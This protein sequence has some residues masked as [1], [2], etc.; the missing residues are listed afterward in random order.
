MKRR[1]RRGHA[2]VNRTLQNDFLNLFTRHLIAQR[3]AHMHF[4]FLRAIEGNGHAQRHE[5]PRMARKSRARPDFSPCVACDQVL[6]RLG[7]RIHPR[8]RLIHVLIAKHRPAHFE[9]LRIAIAVVHSL[10][11]YSRRN[12]FTAPVNC[13]GAST[14]A[15]CEAGTSTHWAPGMPFAKNCASRGGVTGSW[16]PTIMRV[17]DL[18]AETDSRKSPSRTAAQHAAYP[19]PGV[20]ISM[21]RMDSSVAG[22]LVKNSGVNHRSRTAG[23]IEG[24]PP[25]FTLAIRAFHV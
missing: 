12:L 16:L 19:S 4:E 7:E 13:P 18:I 6:E 17:L 20:S 1:I 15:R 25:S 8:K 21:R 22:A 2:A 3:R 23:A 10:P 14:F 9:S 24:M 11:S 5:A